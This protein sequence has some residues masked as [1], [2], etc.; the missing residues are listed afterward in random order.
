M[1]SLLVAT[2]L[3]VVAILPFAHGAGR[4]PT[5]PTSSFTAPL[6]QAREFD[7]GQ[8]IKVTGRVPRRLARGTAIL[9]RNDGARRTVSS[10]RVDARRRY[11]LKT[12]APRK[13]GDYSFQVRIRTQRVEA[14][15]RRLSLTVVDPTPGPTE[16]L[17]PVPTG[18]LG[19][20]HDWSYIGGTRIVRWDPC[21]A[22]T[23]S[24]TG[25]APYAEGQA[26][27]DTAFARISAATGLTFVQVADPEAS[28]LDVEW[29]TASARPVLAGSLVAYGGVSSYPQP[30][31]QSKAVAGQVLLDVEHSMPGGFTAV[32]ASWGKAMLHEMGHAVGLGHARG[33]EQIMYSQVAPTA[34]ELGAGDLSGLRAVGAGQGCF[35]G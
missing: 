12:P 21:T 14:T 13:P 18:P 24:V 19:D 33:A 3:G 8:T 26:D 32:G 1:K 25:T 9:V 5:A 27:L 11:V 17:D 15:I 34:A 28:A 35:A 6:N 16:S 22:I 4:A 31:G 20:P 10:V 29:T 2:T 30:N 7:P 23:W